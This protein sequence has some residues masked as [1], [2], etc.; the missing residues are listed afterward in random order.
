M[1]F[2]GSSNQGKSLFPK[3]PNQESRLWFLKPSENCVL[4]VWS[5]QLKTRQR[6]LHI[7]PGWGRLGWGHG[8]CVYVKI[9]SVNTE[10]LSHT[11]IEMHWQSLHQG[12]CE[13]SF[14]WARC[15]VLFFHIYILKNLFLLISGNGHLLLT[16]ILEGVG[17]GEQMLLCPCSS[18]GDLAGLCLG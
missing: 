15:K 3:R 9:T 18:T 1:D 6:F 7:L 10:V 11:D 16:R 14:K 5:I 17:L 8:F 4:L 2:G 12:C 13:T